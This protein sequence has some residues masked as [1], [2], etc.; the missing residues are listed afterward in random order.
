[1][2][3]LTNVFTDWGQFLWRLKV[4]MLRWFQLFPDEARRPMAVCTRRSWQSQ[5]LLRVSIPYLQISFGLLESHSLLLQIKLKPA[6]STYAELLSILSMQGAG[7][8]RRIHQSPFYLNMPG[9]TECSQPQL[10]ETTAA[11]SYCRAFHTQPWS[12]TFRPQWAIPTTPSRKSPS[13]LQ[14]R[15]GPIQQPRVEWVKNTAQ[16]QLQTELCSLIL[17]RKGKAKENKRIRPLAV[18]GHQ[19]LCPNLQSPESFYL[20]SDFTEYSTLSLAPVRSCGSSS[21][22]IMAHWLVKNSKKWD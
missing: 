8:S 10:T 12:A 18:Q 6:A 19:K 1:M 13:H 9:W 16:L 22:P 4:T 2:L 7:K 5:R 14:L 20:G 3:T 11:L 21:I 15:S 17:K